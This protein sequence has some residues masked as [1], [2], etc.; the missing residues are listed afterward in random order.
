MATTAT[1]PT[2][3][4]PYPTGEDSLSN[5]AQRIQ[6]LANRIETT[7]G[8][9]GIDTSFTNLLQTGDAA[10]GSLTGSYPNPTIATNAINNTMIQDNAISTA[11]V[12]DGAITTSKIATSVNLNG[13][14][15]TTTQSTSDNS[16]KIATTSFVNAV[17]TN[18]QA[19][20]VAANS[21]TNAQINDT[22]GIVYSK[23]DL[24]AYAGHTVCT[25]STNPASPFNGQMVWETDTK[26]LKVY[27]GTAWIVIWHTDVWS[28]NSVGNVLQG[29]SATTNVPRISLTNT[30]ADATSSNIIMQKSRTSG[31]VSSADVIGAINFNIHDGT[32]YQNGARILA[33]ADGASSAGSTPSAITFS[34]VL[35]GS[36]SFVERLRITNT[37]I[38][39]IGNGETAASPNAGSVRGTSGSGS[40][41]NGASFNI[42]G[43]V[44][45]GTGTGGNVSVYTALAGSA[46]ST[47]N[48]ATERFRIDQNGFTT[49]QSG[50]F[51]RSGAVTKTANFTVATNENYIICNNA[52]N[53]ALTV[54]LPTASS[55]SGR[56]IMIKNINGGSAASVISA[57]SNVVPINS[58]TTGTTILPIAQAGAWATIVS[59]GTNWIITESNTNTLTDAGHLIVAN[60][61]ARP[62][63]PSIGQI[64]YQSD[65]GEFLKWVTDIDNTQRWMQIHT[66]YTPNRNLLHNSLMQVAQRQPGPIQVTN[67]AFASG[68]PGT[69]TLTTA[70]N[71]GIRS[72]AI[73]NVSI[74]DSVFDGIFTIASVPSATTLTYARTD[75][76]TVA[77]VATSGYLTV[78]MQSVTATATGGAAPYSMVN[79][80]NA[81]DRWKNTLATTPGTFTHSLER[82]AP[83]GTIL[84]NSFKTNVTTINT[85][86]T[87]AQEA[88]LSQTIEGQNAQVLR[89]GTANALP[90]VLSFWVKSSNTGTYIAELTDTQNTRQI[91]KSYTINV[92]DTWEKKVIT[93]PADTTGVL[94]NDYTA[95]LELSFWLAAGATYTGGTLNSSAWAATTNANR[96]VG[97][98]NLGAGNSV[99]T[100]SA[101]GT[102]SA[103]ILGTATLGVA[104]H[105]F[106]VGQMI[107]VAG[108]TP[109]TFN[110]T[111]Q[112]TATTATS[113]SYRSN[114]VGPQTVAGTIVGAYWQVSGVQ[115]EIGTAPSELEVVRFE[116]DLLR[117]Q[118]YYY[119]LNNFSAATNTIASGVS[120]SATANSSVFNYPVAMRV[121]PSSIETT[122]T[123]ADYGVITGGGGLTAASA[124]PSFAN[125]TNKTLAITSTVAAGLTAGQGGN[126]YFNSVIGS[127]LGFNADF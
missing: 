46:G 18:F 126:I 70:T 17:A 122:T 104:S 83:T 114:A 52:S 5:L 31:I 57:S 96:A 4:F 78:V 98:T 62:S 111:Y 56:E 58:S 27:N 106:V 71:H 19:G 32:G 76:T 20:Y 109:A 8:L 34:T 75:T 33:L 117:C 13:S 79:G 95:A 80:Y 6:D 110:G 50:S 16:T 85:T 15:T 101:T 14:P 30:T 28:F 41:I 64:I 123:A 44:G 42:Y 127:Y 121:S 26:F 40:N 51:G 77:S 92:K 118:R 90:T 124:V 99:A 72:G 63:T 81:A 87:G 65:T 55:W 125:G 7:Y 86:L 48:T 1:T 43:G 97:Q 37:G 88:R 21:I 59:D 102:G 49:L 120:T 29:S 108:V 91:S 116:D 39:Y 94:F 84:R 47:L 36:T 38:V 100:T 119:R 69:V 112:V 22:A 107:T 35:S 67:K 11:E 60:T 61:G 82:D 45:T 93:I 68:A 24:S 53:A 105:T 113:V 3:L 115:F 2:Y 74:G 25:S 66:A 12:A 89:K 23:L 9:M 103:T 73:I 10:G 54:T